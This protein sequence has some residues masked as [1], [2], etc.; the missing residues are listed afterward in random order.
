M[1]VDEDLELDT[2]QAPPPKQRSVKKIILWSVLGLLL[3]GGGTAGGLYFAGMLPGFA[4][5]DDEAADSADAKKDS[6]K[7]GAK[8]KGDKKKKELEKPI[9]YEALDPS[10]VVNFQDQAQVR[11]LQITIELS[12]RD[13]EVIEAVKTHMPVIRSNLI[14]LLSSQNYS[15]ISTRE[16]KEALRASTLAE[17]KKILEERAGKSEVEDVYFTSFVMQ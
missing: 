6:K 13:P 15:D 8:G 3:V 4:A 10:F 5:Q 1:P 7:K 2:E 16:G 14:L 17:I 12:S 9:I 11:F